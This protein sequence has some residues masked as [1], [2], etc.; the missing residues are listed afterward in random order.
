MKLKN[1]K[2]ITLIALV[3]SIIVVTVISGS[4]IYNTKNQLALKRLNNLN[5]DINAI[6]SRVDEYYI[7]YG[8]LPVV[9]SYIEGKADFKSKIQEI[10]T[11][12]KA[13]LSYNSV[14][15]PN[16]ND[17]YYVI[18]LEKLNNLTVNYGYDAQY[19]NV[20]NNG[21]VTRINLETEVYVINGLTHQ[22][23]FPHGIFVD[24]VMYY[25]YN[26]DEK[27]VSINNP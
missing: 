2:G 6:S 7:K 8:E 4:I 19:K 12:K 10:A 23:Y 15:N 17:N 18:D 25:T 24:D 27:V 1:E 9:C 21:E 11:S 22:I 16:D 13:T 26:L 20:K 3:V 14:V 5:L